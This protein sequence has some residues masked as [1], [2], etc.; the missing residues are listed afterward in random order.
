MLTYIFLPLI[1]QLCKHIFFTTIHLLIML[2]YIFYIELPIVLPIELPIELSIVLLLLGLLITYWTY[3]LLQLLPPIGTGL[4][5][6]AQAL[7]QAGPA[8]A[9]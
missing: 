6:P 8:Q 2:P 9:P 5:F 7:N 4:C 1:Y 3:C